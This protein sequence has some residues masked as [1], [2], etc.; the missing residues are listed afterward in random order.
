MATDAIVHKEGTHGL[1][2]TAF[3]VELGRIR[4]G[5]PDGDNTQEQ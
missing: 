2:K 4:C 1:H 5:S 3:E